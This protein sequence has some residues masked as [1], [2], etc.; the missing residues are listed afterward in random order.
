MSDTATTGQIALLLRQHQEDHPEV[1]SFFKAIH[2]FIDRTVVEFFGKDVGSMPFPV[3]SFEPIPGERRG[4]YRPA[5]GYFLPH[6]IT[7]DPF[8]M[9]TGLDAAEILAHELVHLWMQWL[10]YPMVDNVHTDA[11]HEKMADY[12]IMSKGD[13]GDHVGLIGEVW[14]DWLEHNEDLQLASYAMGDVPNPNP[15][16]VYRCPR[17]HLSVLT[18]SKSAKMTCENTDDCFDEMEKVG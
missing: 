1:G 17:C 13:T 10:G 16:H 14:V 4:E 7:V 2:M 3:V 9:D 15:M 12:G 6:K 18:H 8:K 5:D 11:F